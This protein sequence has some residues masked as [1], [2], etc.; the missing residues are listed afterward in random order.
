MNHQCG[1]IVRNP[2]G[3]VQAVWPGVRV[4]AQ[5]AGHARLGPGP[6]R[7]PRHG[8]RPHHLR[9]FR[10]RHAQT[11]VPRQRVLNIFV[12]HCARQYTLHEVNPVPDCATVLNVSWDRRLHDNKSTYSVHFIM[13]IFLG[14]FPCLW[15][16]YV[17]MY[18]I[19]NRGKV[20]SSLLVASPSAQSCK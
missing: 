10:G 12:I 16:M 1:Y 3:G 8:R 2:P 11:R 6:R 20:P 14:H 18:Y 7:R 15:Q 17:C 9:G 5:D 13:K 4:R 19:L